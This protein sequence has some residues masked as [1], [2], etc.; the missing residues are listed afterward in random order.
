MEG[1]KF[2]LKDFRKI[3]YKPLNLQKILLALT[4]RY[5]LHFFKL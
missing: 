4:L 2:G 3:T 5:D 1:F